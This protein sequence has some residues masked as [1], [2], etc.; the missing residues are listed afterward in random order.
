ML[1]AFHNPIRIWE[2][3]DEMTMFVGPDRAARLLEVGV[4]DS[5]DD[6]PVMVHAM[7]VRDK[8]LN[9]R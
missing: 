7:P 6:G 2:L 4:V 1:H 5:S 9:R 3:D 8:F